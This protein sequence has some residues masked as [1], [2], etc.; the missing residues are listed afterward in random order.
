MLCAAI[1]IPCFAAAIAVAALI[2]SSVDFNESAVGTVAVISSAI[3]CFLAAYFVA[4]YLRSRGMIVGAAVGGIA[5][6]FIFTTGLIAGE[7]VTLRALY[8]MAILVCA[9]ALGGSLGVLKKEKTR[10]HRASKAR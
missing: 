9:G 6:L 5:F 2:F 7:A 8:K 4:K 1:I 10:K 3:G